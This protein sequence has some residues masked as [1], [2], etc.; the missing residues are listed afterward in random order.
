MPP[1]DDDHHVLAGEL[2][3]ARAALLELARAVPESRIYRTTARPGWTLKH[4][5]AAL[6]AADRELLHVFEQLRAGA[7]AH[8]APRELRRRFGEAMHVAQELR[9][10]QLLERLATDVERVVEAV[11][12]HPELSEPLEQTGREAASLSD[13]VRDH[14]RRALEAAEL[15]R[16]H[17]GQ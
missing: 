14:A 11:L 12:G 1:P 3:D 15:F 5:L 2:R 8:A 6:A 9:F 17:A 16:S 13:L 7:F 4:E 10:P